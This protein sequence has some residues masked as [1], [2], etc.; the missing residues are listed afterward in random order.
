MVVEVKY[1]TTQMAPQRDI[2]TEFKVTVYML[3]KGGTIF[4]SETLT[5]TNA[6]VPIQKRPGDKCP[7][8]LV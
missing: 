5:F 1:N 3:A 6:D 2:P 7:D 4:G 8:A